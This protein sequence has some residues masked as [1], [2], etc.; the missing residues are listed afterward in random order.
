MELGN[1]HLESTELIPLV[2]DV[3]NQ[4]R[5]N[6]VFSQFKPQIVFHA[7]AYKHVPLMELNTQEV[8]FNNIYGTKQILDTAAKFEV[9]RCV[10]IS[11][12]KAVN[13]TNCM[14]AT[15]RVAEVLMQLKAAET[16]TTTFAAVRFGNVLGSQGSVVPLFKKQIAA[17]GPITVTHP[18]VT[19]FFMTIPEAVRLVIQAGA[20]AAGG[21][22]FVL[23]MGDSV[24]IIDLAKDMV[25]LSGLELGRDIEI[26][27]TGL[28]P[29]EKLYEE[30]FYNKE[31]LKTTG[32]KKIFIA[33]PTLYNKEVI[34]KQIMTLLS[35]SAQKEDAE[36][37]NQLFSLVQTLDPQHQ[38]NKDVR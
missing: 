5:L 21:E 3:K 25:H 27:F 37:R 35:E 14:G 30:L 15:K 34:L 2:C 26:K 16:T 7:A 9:E 12:D 8:I 31:G 17:G 11:T 29:G 13:P 1:L 22:I 23:D 10:L 33:E 6:Q 4:A 24:K 20:L 19:R 28:R 18:E 38:K 32:N 36:L